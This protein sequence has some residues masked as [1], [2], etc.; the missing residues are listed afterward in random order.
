MLATAFLTLP[1]RRGSGRARVPWDD[2]ALAA[3]GFAAAAWFAVGYPTLV[4]KIFARPPEVWI[5][6]LILIL[7]I[8]E[9]LAPRNRLGA[10]ADHRGVPALR[11][12]SAT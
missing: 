10:G 2:L 5:P 12:C 4:L 9:A 3:I 11:R 1:A 6:G 7:L 8:L